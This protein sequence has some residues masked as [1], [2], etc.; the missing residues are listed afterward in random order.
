MF[1]SRSSTQVR[2][3]P[4][5]VEMERQHHTGNR[6]QRLYKN[7]YCVLRWIYIQVSSDLKEWLCYLQYGE[8]H[9]KMLMDPENICIIDLQYKAMHLWKSIH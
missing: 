9:D 6:C 1:S 4:Q 5:A 3:P 7:P 2:F 8:P